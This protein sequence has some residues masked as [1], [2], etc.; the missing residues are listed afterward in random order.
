MAQRRPHSNGIACLY[1]FIQIVSFSLHR[2]NTETMKLCCIVPRD[3]RG[4]GGS[5]GVG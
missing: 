2:D 4:G 5:K 3:E 1:N